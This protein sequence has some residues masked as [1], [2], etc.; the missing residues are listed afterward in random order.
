MNGLFSNNF[1]HLGFLLLFAMAHVGFCADMATTKSITPIAEIQ[2]EI[3]RLVSILSSGEGI[4]SEEDVPELIR[5]FSSCEGYSAGENLLQ[6]LLVYGGRDEQRENPSAEMSKRTLVYW[7]TVEMSPSDVV[8]TI[9]PHLDQTT[10][11]QL[12]KNLSR[13]LELVALGKKTRGTD[14]SAFTEYIAK[15]KVA[16][17]MG[18]VK[19]MYVYDSEAALE[20]ISEIYTGNAHKV[21]S[22][23]KRN[24]GVVKSIA[25]GGEWWQELYAVQKMRQSSKLRDFELIERLK[26]SEH[27]IVR[28]AAQEIEQKNPTP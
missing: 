24:I 4:S 25:K 22:I 17:P 6:V 8:A 12:L 15:H 2:G 9:A 13:P 21:A 16:P 7:L 18:L 23:E 19:R 10:D 5:K 27:P 11:P 20:G 3:G 14:F 1:R 26:K 28:E